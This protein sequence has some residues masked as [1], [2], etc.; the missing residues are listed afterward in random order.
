ML[1]KLLLTVGAL[2]TL[3]AMHLPGLAIFTLGC[4][5]AMALLHCH[6]FVAAFILAVLEI[7]NVARSAVTINWDRL[8]AMWSTKGEPT[9]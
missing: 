7:L 9:A 8:R 5:G 6:W 2:I 4:I 1:N 3:I